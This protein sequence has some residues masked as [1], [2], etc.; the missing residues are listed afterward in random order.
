MG[1]RAKPKSS[2]GRL[3]GGWGWEQV[4]RNGE[5]IGGTKRVRDR[6]GERETERYRDRARGRGTQKGTEMEKGERMRVNRE[7]P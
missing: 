3:Q 5:K 7:G 1:G 2:V 4:I 6:R